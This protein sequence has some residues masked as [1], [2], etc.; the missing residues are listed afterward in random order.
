MHEAQSEFEVIS[1]EPSAWENA[2]AA[3]A[4]LGETRVVKRFIGA[5]SGE[6]EARLL[7]A[8]TSDHTATYVAIEAFTGEVDGRAGGFTL[9]HSSTILDGVPVSDY[10]LVVPDSGT[11]ELEGINGTGSFRV[12]DAGHHVTLRYD[13][14]R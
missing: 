12:D 14:V 3:H 13:L 1:W 8:R 2:P 4:E 9:A 5:I 10:F 11:G 7:T 6:S